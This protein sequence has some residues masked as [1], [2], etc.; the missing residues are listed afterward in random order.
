[1]LKRILIASLILITFSNAKAQDKGAMYSNAVDYAN[2]KLTYAYLNQFTTPLSA[3]K[4]EKKS[5]NNIRS[6]FNNCKIGNSI[7]YSKLSELL[8]ANNF[9]TSNQKFSTVINEIKKSYSESYSKDE[10]VNKILEQIYSNPELKN[11]REKNSDID[12]LK[13]QLASDISTYFGDSFNKADINV[14]KSQ[15]DG[16]GGIE[17]NGESEISR[18]DKKIDNITPGIFSPNWLSIIISVFLIIG[19]FFLLKKISDIKKSVDRHGD[20]ARSNSN[21]SNNWIQETNS[22]LSIR[23]LAEYKKSIESQMI[24]A[25]SAISTLQKQV[26]QIEN[27]LP[28]QQE[29]SFNT[30]PSSIQQ[31][32]QQKNDF[33]YSSIPEKDGSFNESAITNSMNPT[34]SY[35]KF[36]IKDSHTATFE[37]INDERAVKDATN[38]PELILYPV[39]KIK[40]SSSQ[41]AKKIRTITH[42]TVVKRND[43]WEL[44]TK[45]EI[46]YE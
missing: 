12:K 14:P 7:P 15:T 2:C 37:F 21:L 11:A 4:P 33:F 17:I 46:L 39:C 42:G 44:G 13:D 40:G 1:M 45:A 28:K 6:Q 38:S 43:K 23:E 24:G 5:F 10:A 34:S 16:K 20:S 29:N 19:F 30:S 22:N 25:L 32:K 18:L 41:G 3:E 27:S 35:Y 26:G 36:T 9:K 31:E 8:I